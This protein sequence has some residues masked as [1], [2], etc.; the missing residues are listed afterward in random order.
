MMADMMVIFRR[1]F[2][3]E[4]GSMALIAGW[5]NTLGSAYPARQNPPRNL[6][7]LALAYQAITNA[8]ICLQK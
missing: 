7:S 4:M 5:K 3:M 2:G 6:G 1:G 8:G